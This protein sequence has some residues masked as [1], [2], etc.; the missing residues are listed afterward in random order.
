MCHPKVYYHVFKACLLYLCTKP[1]GKYQFLQRLNI[2]LLQRVTFLMEHGKQQPKIPELVST[3]GKK[4]N[5]ILP[6]HY[7]EL[8]KTTLAKRTKVFLLFL[9]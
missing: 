7:F 8:T 3:L 5:L 9:L 2:V 6:S 1:G 4:V